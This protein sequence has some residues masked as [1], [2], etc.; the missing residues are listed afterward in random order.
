VGGGAVHC[1]GET[2]GRQVSATIRLDD[3]Q[4]EALAVRIAVHLAALEGTPTATAATTA[5]DA[6]PLVSAAEL[7]RLLGVSR[8]TVYGAAAELGGVRVGTGPRARW[9]FDPQTAR[10]RMMLCS[11]GSTPD[12]DPASNGGASEPAPARRRSRLPNQ[13]PP[14]GSILKVRPRRAA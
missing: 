6:Q 9:R 3:D 5:A 14:A 2:V 11:R 7:A 10:E 1:G 8:Q 12:A 13:L 4:L